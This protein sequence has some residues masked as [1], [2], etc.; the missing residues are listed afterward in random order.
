MLRRLGLR[1]TPRVLFALLVAVSG[2][3][4]EDGILAPTKPSG[5]PAALADLAT[6][7]GGY[8]ATGSGETGVC[9][10]FKWNATQSGSSVSGESGIGGLGRGESFTDTMRG[11]M[12]AVTSGGGF[13]VD[14][15][16][17]QRLFQDRT[18]SVSGNGTVNAGL[19]ALSGSVTL[20]WTPGCQGTL[21]AVP[22]AS[23]PLRGTMNL[24]KNA[25]ARGCP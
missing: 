12:T 20:D 5:P 9:F 17:P 14:I 24:F 16:F 22:G 15:V 11:T 3:C 21:F 10:G 23:N 6:T 4:S 25:D 13:A 19:S 8:I 18:C 1:L 2:S 7:W